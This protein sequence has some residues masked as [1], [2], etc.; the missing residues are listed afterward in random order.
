MCGD[1]RRGK[2]LLSHPLSSA[3]QV[4]EHP[5]EASAV[6]N[7]EDPTSSARPSLGK[8]FNHHMKGLGVQDTSGSTPLP[9]CPRWQHPLETVSGSSEFL[10]FPLPCCCCAGLCQR[11]PS[12]ITHHLPHKGVVILQSHTFPTVMLLMCFP[13]ASFSTGRPA[14]LVMLKSPTLQWDGG[15]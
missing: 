11:L 10:D 14:D 1:G 5:A 9:F 4:P 6:G 8:M 15:S 13:P 2:R 3:Q 12:A 7:R